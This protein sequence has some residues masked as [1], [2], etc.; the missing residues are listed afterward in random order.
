MSTDSSWNDQFTKF[1]DYLS[2][3]FEFFLSWLLNAAHRIAELDGHPE[4]PWLDWARY[5]ELGVDNN[6][7]VRLLDDEII[8]EREVASEMGKRLEEIGDPVS[9]SIEQVVQAGSDVAGLSEAGLSRVATWYRQ[10]S[11]IAS[12]SSPS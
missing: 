8:L 6:W 4:R 9:V 10:R 5:V 3:C 2:D 1:N 7:A 11:L 12:D